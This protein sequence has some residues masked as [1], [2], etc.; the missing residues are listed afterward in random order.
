[1]KEEGKTEIE[2]ERKAKTVHQ[3]YGFL[4][5]PKRLERERVTRIYE[6]LK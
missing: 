4:V 3:K 6:Y 5:I 1:M 2:T